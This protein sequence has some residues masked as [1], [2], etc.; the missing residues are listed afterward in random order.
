MCLLFS[1]PV[2]RVLKSLLQVRGGVSQGGTSWIN[3]LP[4]ML[5]PAAQGYFPSLGT[6]H[7]D[8]VSL[9]FVSPETAE[10]L[11]DEFLKPGI[12]WA[13]KKISAKDK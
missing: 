12:R 1:Y 7:F 2:S 3:L 8:Y 4:C 6:D 10:M 11:V 13:I 9:K 5:Y